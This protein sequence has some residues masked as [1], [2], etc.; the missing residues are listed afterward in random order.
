M[1]T[2]EKQNKQ[3]EDN[4]AEFK[5]KRLASFQSFF[6]RAVRTSEN[7]L[8]HPGTPPSS[9]QTVSAAPT[10]TMLPIPLTPPLRVASL[11]SALDATTL[12][13]PLTPSL[14]PAS[15]LSAANEIME[16]SPVVIPFTSP[17]S[18]QLQQHNS[19]VRPYSHE[20]R[21]TVGYPPVPKTRAGR[22]DDEI[23]FNHATQRP[24]RWKERAR[25]FFCVCD[26]NSSVP[27]NGTQIKRCPNLK[28]LNLFPVSNSITTRRVS[29]V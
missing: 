3:R 9:T 21:F 24:M 25:D 18:S 1:A 29:Q 6:A 28:A 22:I 15:V 2:L 10:V 23:Y 16:D 20:D 13:K 5:Q 8:T 7:P 4:D 27:C 26:L 11:P 17:H 14:G 19:P 12:L